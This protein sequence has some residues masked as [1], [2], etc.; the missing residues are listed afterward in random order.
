MKHK[1]HT[2]EESQHDQ[3]AMETVEAHAPKVAQPTLGRLLLYTLAG[4]TIRPCIVTGIEGDGFTVSVLTAGAAD[5]AHG[6][7]VVIET[8]V[9]VSA[10]STPGAMH[11][12][13]HK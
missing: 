4:G 8:G 3:K 1:E 9:K 2:H 11:W 5:N 6:N 7:L 13:A 10:E 12:P